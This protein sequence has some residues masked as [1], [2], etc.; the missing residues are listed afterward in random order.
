MGEVVRFDKEQLALMQH[1][2]AKEKEKWDELGEAY[3]WAE[4][5]RRE[6]GF[7][8][9]PLNLTFE[10]GD[11]MGERDGFIV[12][13]FYKKETGEALL[14]RDWEERNIIQYNILLNFDEILRVAPKATHKMLKN[15]LMVKSVWGGH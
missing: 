7:L 8:A 11:N 4:K 12:S 2:V 1:V 5:Q 9:Q 10:H 13:L 3:D 6:F 14:R 15:G